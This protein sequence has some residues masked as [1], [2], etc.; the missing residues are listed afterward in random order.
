MEEQS[1]TEVSKS[2]KK[3]TFSRTQ[4]YIREFKNLRRRRRGQRRLKNDFI[5]TYESRD[6]F[7]S[8]SLFFF[9]KAISKLNM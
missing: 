4:V 2:I 7:K 8:F 3:K 1:Y 9:V 6:T 5:F